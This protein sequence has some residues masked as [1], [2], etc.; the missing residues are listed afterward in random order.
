MPDEN[1]LRTEIGDQSIEHPD[2]M[3]L[4]PPAADEELQRRGAT[5]VPVGLDRQ[6]AM[7]RVRPRYLVA[8]PIGAREDGHLVPL[9]ARPS[10]T[11][12]Q[13]CM[14]PQPYWQGG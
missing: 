5:T 14:Y 9:A 11:S 3:S 12:S 10:A 1:D 4:A 2:S 7:Y 6:Q 13:S 8:L